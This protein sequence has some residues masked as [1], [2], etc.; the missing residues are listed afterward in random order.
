MADIEE[1]KALLATLSAY[2]NFH[3]WLYEELVKPRSIRLRS[4]TELE[5][6][7]LPWYE[8]HTANL[9]ECV[10]LNSHFCS[11][12]AITAAKQW[13]IDENPTQWAEPSGLD[14]DKVRS[15]LLQFSREWS[16][17]GEQERQISFG[18]ILNEALERY[19]DIKE[20]PLVNVL[21]PGCGLGR[22]VYEFVHQGFKCQGN[23]F[24]YHM[25]L[26][27]SYVLNNCQF[28]NEHSILPYIFKASHVKKRSLQL[29][30]ITIPD[31]SAREIHTLQE[32]LPGV[33]ISELMSMTAGSF[34]E[35]YGPES[36]QP[37]DQ[38][39]LAQGTEFRE[40]VKG[41]FDIIC[42]CFFLDTSYN[43]IDYLKTI[44]HCLK[45]N[46][47]IWINFGPL[48]WHFEDGAS[49]EYT[50]K[51]LKDGEQPLT[52]PTTKK[53]MELSLEDLMALMEKMGFVIEKHES[54]IKTSYSSDPRAMSGYIY[55]CEFWVARAAT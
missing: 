14:L 1:W 36:I 26:A 22:L 10:N 7:L 52:V 44:K 39:Q 33:D 9:A 47:G 25:L 2:Y 19:P 41:T 12:L 21:I 23:E 49:V 32:K 29:R 15:T 5:R 31:V 46:G 40:A 16:S 3:K 11:N 4:M 54:G 55:E 45:Q 50:T 28:A 6:N 8:K 13:G 24:S 53:G 18:R 17:E 37:I 43:I 34:T 42:T 30:P 48:L 51:I 35:V 20:R 27:S 38:E